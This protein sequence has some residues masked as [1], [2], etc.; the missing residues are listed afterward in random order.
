LRLHLSSSSA[1]GYRGVHEL[2]SGRF[3][4][5]GKASGRSGRVVSI[6]AFDTAVEAAVEYARAFGAAGG[7][8]TSGD[9]VSED[10]ML[11]AAAAAADPEEIVTTIVC[12]GCEA[13][14]ELLP[15]EPVPDGDWFCAACKPA[16]PQG[17]AA[18]ADETAIG[19][20]QFGTAPR[21]SGW[22][23]PARRAGFE[24]GMHS[25]MDP[26][27]CERNPRCTRGYKHGGLGGHCRL[28]RRDTS[29]GRA[30]A[31]RDGGLQGG[32]LVRTFPRTL[33]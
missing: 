28:W 32:R 10:A 1:T 23:A 25:G 33:L 2:A 7:S 6:G 3:R 15:G 26:G 24:P 9:G 11:A 4:A 31:R 30:P 18:E 12:D 27:Q 17:I 20:A 14:F 22:R 13:E 21:S 29:D 19:G 16:Q 8:S 5:Q